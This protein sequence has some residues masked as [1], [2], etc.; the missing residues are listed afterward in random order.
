MIVDWLRLAKSELKKALMGDF[1]NLKNTKRRFRAGVET[2]VTFETIGA[3]FGLAVV[4]VV[5]I[6]AC[7]FGQN[8]FEGE[9][10][11]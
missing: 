3:R 5:A 10:G 1:K 11:T 9:K 2:T 6:S 8:R 7:V 4:A